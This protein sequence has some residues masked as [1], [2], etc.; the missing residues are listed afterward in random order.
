M[1][2]EGFF[3]LCAVLSVGISHITVTI[4]VIDLAKRGI[5]SSIPMQIFMTIFTAIAYWAV[6][7]IPIF[8]YQYFAGNA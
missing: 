7:L 6:V 8:L 4:Q 5:A 3:L 2:T 1:K